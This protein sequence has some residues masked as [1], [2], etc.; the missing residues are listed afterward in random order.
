M[1]SNLPRVLAIGS[2]RIFRPLR[3]LHEADQIELVN[4]ADRFWFTHTA[5]AA[6][7][8]VD[9]MEGRVTI[10]AEIRPAALETDLEWPEDMAMGLPEVD[11]VVV[12]VS[13]LKEQMLGD[14]KLNAH[15][16]YGI[17]N[18]PGMDYRPIVQGHTEALPED[19][20]LKPLKVAYTSTDQLREDLRAIKEATGAPMMVVDHIYSL[21]PTGEVAPGRAKLTSELREA[22]ADVGYTF[23]ST[24]NLIVERGPDV[25]LTDQNHYRGDFEIEVGKDFMPSIRSLLR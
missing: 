14:Y 4:Y 3:K 7:Q 2:C 21:T 19:H 15:K 11:A 16:V 18:Q 22:A 10:P 13:S 9:V 23:H 24:R 5:A 1:T 8:Y 25:A 20:V 17:A 6:R 12:E